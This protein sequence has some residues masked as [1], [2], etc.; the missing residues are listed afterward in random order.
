MKTLLRALILVAAL[1]IVT[2]ATVLAEEA[3]PETTDGFV[4]PVLGGEA[5][6][7]ESDS[8]PFVQISGGDYTIIGPDVTVPL[9]ATNDNGDGTPGGDYA[10]LGEADYTAIWAG[11]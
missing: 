8:T 5:G 2:V 4:C 9:L 3:P 6:Q 10:S 11:G 1:S 7:Q